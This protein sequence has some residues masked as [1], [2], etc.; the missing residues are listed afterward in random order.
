MKHEEVNFL[1]DIKDKQTGELLVGNQLYTLPTSKLPLTVSPKLAV[2]MAETFFLNEVKSR[3]Y[4]PD[5]IYHCLKD[6][7]IKLDVVRI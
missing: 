6:V 5:D 4:H 3:C 7:N 2:A 1:I